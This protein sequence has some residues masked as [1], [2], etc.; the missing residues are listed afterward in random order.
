MKNRNLT[1]QI[2]KDFQEDIS[3]GEIEAIKQF[4]NTLKSI[5]KLSNPAK[6]TN[7]RGVLLYAKYDCDMEKEIDSLLEGLE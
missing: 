1:L 7:G 5:I 3:V 2:W 4:A 6:F